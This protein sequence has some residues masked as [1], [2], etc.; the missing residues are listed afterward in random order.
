MASRSLDPVSVDGAGDD[1]DDL[2]TTFNAM[3]GKLRSADAERRR[4]VSDASHELRTPLMVLS[5]D[6]EYV[7]DHPV[8]PIQPEA[9]RLAQTV[10]D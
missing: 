3:L 8:T 1:I 2:A 7:I 9:E 10:L 5:A 6:A 4:F